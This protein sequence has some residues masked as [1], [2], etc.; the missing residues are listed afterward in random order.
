MKPEEEVDWTLFHLVPETNPVT[1]SEL[2]EKTGYARSVVEES[3]MRLE[4]SCLLTV[5]GEEVHAMS[6]QD[7]LFANEIK[8]SM[9]NDPFLEIENGVIKVKK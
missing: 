1:I 3:L 4:N 7:F 5:I 8:N 9:E 6:I 2:M